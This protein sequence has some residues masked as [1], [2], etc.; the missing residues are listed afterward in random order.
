MEVKVNVEN[1]GPIPGEKC[2]T[3]HVIFDI[4]YCLEPRLL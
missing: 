3:G 1:A 4:D 2:H